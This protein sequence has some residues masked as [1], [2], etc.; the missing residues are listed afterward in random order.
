MHFGKEVG[1]DYL[2]QIINFIYMEL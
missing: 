2:I 1:G